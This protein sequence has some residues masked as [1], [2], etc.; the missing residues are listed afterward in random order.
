MNSHDVLRTA[1]KIGGLA[2]LIYS[3]IQATSYLPLFLDQAKNTGFGISVVSILSTIIVP[4]IFGLLLWLFPAFIA[5]T[6]IKNDLAVSTQDK[7]LVG[8]RKSVV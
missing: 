5:S 3:A 7:F 2:L 6:I 4:I 8:D 1:V